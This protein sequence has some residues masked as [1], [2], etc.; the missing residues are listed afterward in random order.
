MTS[1]RK[2]VANRA[3]AHASTG[4][5]TVLGRAHAA[6]N[7]FRHGLAAA[8]RRNAAAAPE[9]ETFARS[10]AGPGANDEIAQC[11]CRVALAQF[12]L[13]RVDDARRVI[14][15]EL[16]YR[17]GA[18]AAVESRAIEADTGGRLMER[19][20][21]LRALDRYERAAHAK[22]RVAIRALEAARRRQAN[23]RGQPE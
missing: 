7:S 21:N 17:P 18:E 8:T 12:D 20:R 16:L 6:T 11:A 10:I 15:S 23:A 3:N 1:V 2:L 14:L 19:M 5:K 4:P 22:R 13:V 9:V